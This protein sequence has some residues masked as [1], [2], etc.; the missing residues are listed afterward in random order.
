MT[1]IVVVVL[2]VVL[3]LAA[4]RLWLTANRLDRLHVRT[5]AAW[6]ALEGALSR[7]IVATRAAAAAGAFSGPDADR[8]R[9][10]T[11]QADRAGRATRA[12]AENDLSRALSTQPPVKAELAA[13]LLDAGERV[14]LARSFYNDAVRDTRALRAVWFTRLF[15]LAGRAALP[16]YFEITDQVSASASERTAARVVLV[17]ERQRVLLFSFTDPQ[18]IPTWFPTGGGVEPGEDLRTAAVRE[19]LEETGLV[20]AADDLVGPIWRRS[21]QFVFTG[22]LYDQT[23]FYFTACAPPGFE[24]DIAGFTDVER[25]S[26]TGYRW[27]SA[28][29]LTSST[30]TF[31]P[32]ELAARLGEVHRA[33]GHEG[34]AG[35]MVEI[36]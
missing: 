18:G 33:L 6:A 4:L 17:D 2:L 15:R 7:R 31:Y 20:L 23:E 16:D 19:L 10:L 14:A 34:V 36:S 11:R 12:D 5:E 30:D 24:V 32:L 25:H 13:E 26:I 22:V 3:L 28:A 29:D 8:L 27:F 9:Q 1:T 35:R 21:A